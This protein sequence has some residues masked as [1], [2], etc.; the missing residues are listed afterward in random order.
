MVQGQQAA[1]SYALVNWQQQPAEKIALT[2]VYKLI[3]TAM[4]KW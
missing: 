1:V 3:A 4:G 2:D